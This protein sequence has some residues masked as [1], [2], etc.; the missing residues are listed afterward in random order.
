MAR[1]VA[2]IVVLVGFC[3]FTALARAGLA[4]VENVRV[5]RAADGTYTFHVT[6]R[7]ADK[8]WNHYADAW[9]VVLPDGT[10]AGTR[11]LAHP[12]VD[13]QPFT[14]SLWGVKIPSGVEEV[15]VRARDKVH[16][17]GGREMTAKIPR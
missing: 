4:D 6:V 16:G 3:A 2:F 17:F 1:K 15:R 5:E 12:H 9:Q 8:G 14:R 10:V 7:H 13:E 11:E